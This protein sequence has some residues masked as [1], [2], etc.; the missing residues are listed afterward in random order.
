MIRIY[1]VES[2][3][4]GG[5]SHGFY[6]SMAKAEAHLIELRNKLDSTYWAWISETLET[7]ENADYLINH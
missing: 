4:G 3:L 7:V 5:R 1:R 6:R 2:D